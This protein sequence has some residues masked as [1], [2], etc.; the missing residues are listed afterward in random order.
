MSHGGTT[1]DRLR[2]FLR[3]LTSEARAKLIAE[4]E[5][6][7]LRGEH[8]AATGLILT[9]LRK[10]IRESREA[11][12]RYNNAARLFFKLFEPFLVDDVP[13]RRHP[14]RLTRSSLQ[15]IWSFIERDLVPD[16]TAEFVDAA[17]AALGAG[18][19]A[20]SE[21]AVRKLQDAVTLALETRLE[22]ADDRERRHL[23]AQ[24]G[25]PR[26]EEDAVSLMRILQMRDALAML[27]DRLPNY[28]ANFSDTRL[29]E[30]RS[31]LAT[32]TTR[33]P[34]ILPY[35]AAGYAASQRVLAI[36]TV[37]ATGFERRDRQFIWRRGEHRA[38][39]T[40][41]AHRRIAQRTAWQWRADRKPFAKHPQ[42]RAR[43]WYRAQST[44]G[45]PVWP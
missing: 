6:R 34:D 4:L 25:T 39:G 44:A 45:Q 29:S 21:L 38:C 20:K 16:E 15:T 24:I 30:T 5:R 42:Y 9:E 12:P 22:S 17:L 13:A 28:V 43:S 41:A 11:T 18:D 23:I 31:L 32:A 14:G 2:E 40:G 10:M 1:V 3:G 27:A 36:D 8:D 35:A 7:V 26:A 37:G 19:D 33:H